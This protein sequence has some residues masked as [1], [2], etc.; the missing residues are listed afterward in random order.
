MTIILYKTHEDNKKF[1]KLPGL[2]LTATANEHHG[3]AT[4]VQTDIPWTA[5]AQSADDAEI[6]WTRT[7]VQDTTIVNIY[8]PPPSKL[9][10]ISLPDVPSPALYTGDFNYQQT[11]WIY[12]N[13]NADGDS[14]VEWA[15]SI[16]DTLLY[17][18]KEPHLLLST[19][20]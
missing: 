19:L 4:N 20:G 6:E 11:D 16:D 15:S 17:D 1:L 12:K 13:S 5:I 10:H 9:V 3:L 8:K 7:K 2:L 18:P 14:L